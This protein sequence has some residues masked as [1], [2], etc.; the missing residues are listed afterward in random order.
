MGHDPGKK[1][2]ET[3]D[4]SSLANPPGG[5]LIWFIVFMETVTFIAGIYFY[6]NSR[7]DNL[8]LFVEMQ[9]KLNVNFAVVNTLFLVTSGYFV[10]LALNFL[11]NSQRAKSRLFLLI[12]I[13]LGFGFIFVK[14]FEYSEKIK[15][16]YTTSVNLFFTF[17]WFLTFFHFM[18]VVVASIILIVLYFRLK[19]VK[20]NDVTAL[21]VGASLWH[22]C[23]LIWILLFPTLFLIR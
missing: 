19:E 23:D 2:E 5:G 7:Q 4:H 12:G 11:K 13:V 8:E 6:F 14:L 3:K 15:Q 17:Y 20:E 10:A 21:E 22:M 16:G 1:M 18:H 9:K